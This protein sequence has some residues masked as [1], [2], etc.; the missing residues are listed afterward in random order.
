MKV[1]VFDVKGKYALFRRNYTTSSS[2]SYNFPPRTSICGLLGAIMG[3]QNEATQFSKH[4]R[5]FD[6]AHIALRVLVPIRKTTMGV[7]YAETKSGKNQRTRI[8]LELIKEPVYRIYVSEFSQFDQ[9]RN[10]LENNTC[11]FTPYLGQAQFIAKISHVGVFEA[12][13]VF[14]PVVVHSVLKITDGIRIQPQENSILLREQMVLN[15]DDERRPV[16]FA[17]YW[18]EKNARPLEVIKHPNIFRI[19]ELDE[20]ICWMD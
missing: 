19:E 20:N 13:S 8:I 15:M 17:S 16:A 3:I 4:L 7:N 5:I 9:L 6:N 11:V 12:K 2:T 18:V 1:I 14:P 10:H